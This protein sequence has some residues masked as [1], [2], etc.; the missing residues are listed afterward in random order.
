MEWKNDSCIRETQENLIK[1][2]LQNSLPYILL[3]M[4]H[5]SYCAPYPKWPCINYEA[6]MWYPCYMMLFC[7]RTFYSLFLSPIIN[8]VTTPSDM[9][10]V[11]VWPITSIPNPR[12]LKIE[13]WKINQNKIK[14]KENEEQLSLQSS[15]LIAR[16]NIICWSQDWSICIALLVTLFQ[17]LSH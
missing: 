16:Y 13:K 1:S 5:A 7:S 4:V 8:V 11:T 14:W 10:D 6:N 9:T 3:Q 2:S 15:I 17:S 12:V